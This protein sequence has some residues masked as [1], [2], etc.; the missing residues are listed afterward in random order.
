ME[1]NCAICDGPAYRQCPC[2]HQSLILAVEQSE[3][4]VLHPMWDEIRYWVTTQAKAEIHRDFQSR[5]SLRRAQHSKYLY[6]NSGR[7]T[8]EM[9]DRVNHDLK[10]G[11]D[12]DWRAAVQRYPEVLDYFYSLVGWTVRGDFLQGESMRADLVG[13]DRDP[14]SNGSPIPMPMASPPPPSLVPTP[15]YSTRK[16]APLGGESLYSSGSSSGY[17]SA[18]GSGSVCS[19]T[20]SSHAH[21]RAFPNYAWGKPPGVR[22]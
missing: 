18:M 15:F 11:I 4:R 13:K 6:L 8:N 10:R 16:S 3:Q 17:G 22:P 5:S 14:F 19:P 21:A 12:E 2:E 9:L 7:F 20:I 1:P